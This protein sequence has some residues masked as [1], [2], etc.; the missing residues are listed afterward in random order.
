MHFDTPTKMHNYLVSGKSCMYMTTF[1]LWVLHRSRRCGILA[2]KET[3]TMDGVVQQGRC[4]L[5]V[6]H[7]HGGLCLPHSG[8]RRTQ[9]KE[10]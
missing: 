3:R 7:V 10:G 8:E 1:M 2:E 9:W 6:R 4:G 5:C